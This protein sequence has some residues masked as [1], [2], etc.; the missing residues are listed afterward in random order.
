MENYKEWTYMDKSGWNRG[1]WDKEP[2]KAIWIDPVTGYHVSIVR[3]H[4]GALCGYVMVPKSHKMY[5]KAYDDV[6]YECHGGLTFG[7]EKEQDKVPNQ[8]IQYM[9]I[10]RLSS[11]KKMKVFGFDCAHYGDLSP[12]MALN[13]G[14]RE[15][16]YKDW[17]YVKN[18]VEQ[19]ALQF[20]GDDDTAGAINKIKQEIG[21]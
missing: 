12:G 4:T 3:T 19:L 8:T 15:E 7:R 21:L 2:D 5:K 13:F 17:V 9:P 20:W 10:K 6:P 11:P 18:E 14:N 16:I 1:P